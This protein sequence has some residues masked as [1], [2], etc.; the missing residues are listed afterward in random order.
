MI[1]ESARLYAP[2]SSY[3][4]GG[5]GCR[6]ASCCRLLRELLDTGGG[7]WAIYFVGPGGCRPP[8]CV[9]PGSFALGM[10]LRAS[11]RMVAALGSCAREGFAER[12]A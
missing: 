10:G 9:S 7:S 5:C 11:W 8:R 12:R 6:A 4:F 2:Q 1:I 3:D